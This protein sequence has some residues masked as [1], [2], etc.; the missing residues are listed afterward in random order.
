MSTV[1]GASAVNTSSGKRKAAAISTPECEPTSPIPLIEDGNS[2]ALRRLLRRSPHLLRLACGTNEATPLHMCARLNRPGCLRLLLELGAPVEEAT[3]TW[4]TTPL[5]RAAG[6]NSTRALDVLVEMGAAIDG[7]NRRGKTALHYASSRDATASVH[8]LVL[9]GA[10]V[11]CTSAAG[12]TPL[13]LAA[14][15]GSISALRALVAAGAELESRDDLQ[16]T[17]LDAAIVENAAGSVA[18]LLELGA[19]LSTKTLDT[20]FI[21]LAAASSRLGEEYLAVDRTA[22]LR[23][24]ARWGAPQLSADSQWL[25]GAAERCVLDNSEGARDATRTLLLLARDGAWTP[26]AMH[27]LAP[28]HDRAA[29]M[30]FLLVFNRL[31]ALG[32]APVQRTASLLDPSI[33]ALKCTRRDWFLPDRFTTEGRLRRCVAL[34]VTESARNR[35]RLAKAEARV[36]SLESDL[37]ALRRLVHARLGNGNGDG[38]VA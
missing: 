29:V 27:P 18:A 12:T 15:S 36:R 35:A 16:L 23:A 1:G 11:N 25:A 5:I 24:I 32:R 21:D 31:G 4:G 19:E 26:S 37:S 9:A 10:N 30:A 22:S 8:A 34:Q 33:G 14:D 20:Y 2:G 3:N 7:R 6:N 38:A 13:M 17:A 28:L